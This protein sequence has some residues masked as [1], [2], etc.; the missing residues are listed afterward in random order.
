MLVNLEKRRGADHSQVESILE[1]EGHEVL[2]LAFQGF[3]DARR[4]EE[5]G[6]D[7][8]GEDGK[9][10]TH[11]REASRGLETL[12]GEVT[13]KRDQAS[14]RGLTGRYPMDAALNLTPDHFS[15]GVRQRIAESAAAVSYDATISAISST[16]GATVAKLQAEELA[17][18][19]A[20]DFEAFYE[21]ER[22]G[23]PVWSDP[24]DLL[25]ISV[26]GKGIVMRP[27]ALRSQTRKAAEKA[28]PKLVKRTSKGEKRNRKRMAI[29]AAVYSLPRQPRTATDVI[30][31][32]AGETNKTPRPRANHKRVW[33]SIVRSVPTV[34]DEVFAEAERRDPGHTHQVVALVDGNETQ[35]RV[36]ETAAKEYGV[37]VTLV[38]DFIHVT[39]YIW[40][41]AWCFYKEGDPLAEEWVNEHLRRIL[42]G[43]VVGV[44][45]GMRSSATKGPR[46]N[47]FLF[48]VRADR[49]VPKRKRSVPSDG[50]SAH[51]VV[52]DLG[53]CL[54]LP[55][56]EMSAN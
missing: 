42:E 52:G 15:F 51:L 21:A 8:M 34:V 14:G 46:K 1:T 19:S 44:A 39:E 4:N 7:V 37:N 2:R 31:D 36:I 29:V 48:S 50:Q 41:A 17:R 47:N 5:V 30:G 25:V 49:V 6:Q 18:R 24:G 55:L 33:A 23:T 11:H 53:S 40:N 38:L 13:V 3:L 45:A 43:G 27:E 35:I 9:K 54:V 20:V 22:E 16:S 56:D 10:R 12:F 28:T 32:L 26:D